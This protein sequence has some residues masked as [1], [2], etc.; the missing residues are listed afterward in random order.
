MTDFSTQN[1]VQTSGTFNTAAA[2]F[3]AA[4]AAD[5]AT[6]AQTVADLFR[7]G[8]QGEATAA[9]DAARE[10]QPQA[11][12]DALDRM[13]AARLDMS[14]NPSPQLGAQ[15]LFASPAEIGNT[16]RRVNDAGT[17]PPAMPDTTNLT[18]TQKFDVYSSIVETRGNQAAQDALANGDRVILGLRNEN[19]TTTNNGQG[20]YDDRLAVIARDA[21]GT[22]HVSEFNRASTEPTAQYDAN[23]RTNPDVTFRRGDGVDV[24]GDGV[25]ELGRIAE[26]TMDMFETTHPNPASAGT[27]FSLRPTADAVA[28]APN[29]VQR[30]TN[31]DG[32]FN[33]DDPGGS[34]ALNNTFKIHSGSR[35]NTDSAGCTTLHPNDFVSFRDAVTADADQNRWQYVLSHTAP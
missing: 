24:T 9:L 5:N 28:A 23:Q 19:I 2:N 13:V 20:V 16:I 3:S 12:Q 11:V 34:V 32:Y 27:D 31:H 29:G 26:G 10:G 14:L 33:A 7:E 15:T 22:V 21:D 1:T 4:P 25:G 35:N 8:R 17:N 18:D 6:T 30:D